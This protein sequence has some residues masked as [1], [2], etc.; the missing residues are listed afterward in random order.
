MGILK[1]GWE[2]YLAHCVPSDAEP[3]RIADIDLAF[4]AGASYVFSAMLE[5]LD[6]DREPTRDDLRKMRDLHLEVVEWKDAVKA[7]AAL[8]RAKAH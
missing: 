7:R 8:D 2:S 4:H 6:N 1:Q 3:A 5:M